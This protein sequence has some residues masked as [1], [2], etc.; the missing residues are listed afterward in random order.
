MTEGLCKNWRK[1]LSGWLSKLV[2]TGGVEVV[3]EGVGIELLKVT[4][5]GEPV[6]IHE[7]AEE[8]RDGFKEHCET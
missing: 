8:I 4:E 1:Q 6:T 5:T 3:V 7:Q 2:T